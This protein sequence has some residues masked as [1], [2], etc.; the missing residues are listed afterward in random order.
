MSPEFIDTLKS[1]HKFLLDQLITIKSVGVT[2]EKAKENLHD[3]KSS[4]LEHLE[5]ED[6]LLYP[7]LFELAETNEHLKGVLDHFVTE[8]VA[9]SRDVMAFFT[10]LESGMEND[11]MEVSFDEIYKRLAARIATE[12]KILFQEYLDFIVE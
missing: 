7:P 8:M 6:S 11:V 4:L 5:K 9:I 3:M 10:D 2:S 12:E 1:E